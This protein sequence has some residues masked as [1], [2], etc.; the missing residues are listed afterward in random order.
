MPKYLCINLGSKG[1]IS[2]ALPFI[3]YYTSRRS[4]LPIAKPGTSKLEKTLCTLGL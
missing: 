4:I 2:K 3:I 1:K